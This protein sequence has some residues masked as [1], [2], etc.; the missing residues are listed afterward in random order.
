VVL[1]I[2]IPPVVSLA[3]PQLPRPVTN[4]TG[5][6]TALTACQG[7]PPDAQRV[8]SSSA[9]SAPPPVALTR[10]VHALK[11][12]LESLCREEASLGTEILRLDEDREYFKAQTTEYQRKLTETK[13]RKM[14][15]RE[16]LG[17]LVVRK[18][19]LRGLLTQEENAAQRT[20]NAANPRMPTKGW[21]PQPQPAG[22]CER[23]LGR[24]GCRAMSDASVVKPTATDWEQAIS[25]L[26]R[27]AS[28]KS[29][30]PNA[31]TF[32]VV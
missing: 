6:V 24:D 31:T 8:A 2:T 15:I 32:G 26:I 14:R 13:K 23:K 12:H 27:E 20:L 11:L 21:Q 18:T 4:L 30:Y 29:E 19:R 28:N 1:V 7:G 25:N 9:R 17:E 16:A 10:D 22:Q 3:S 5:L